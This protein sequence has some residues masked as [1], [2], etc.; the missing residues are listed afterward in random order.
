MLIEIASCCAWKQ[1]RQT[2]TATQCKHKQE[3]IP[4]KASFWRH[5]HLRMQNLLGLE[6]L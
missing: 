5:S 6:G 3:N 2:T 1:K 4:K